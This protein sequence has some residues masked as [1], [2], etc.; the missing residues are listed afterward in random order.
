MSK[1]STAT[2][3]FHEVASGE[4][5]AWPNDRWHGAIDNCDVC[6]RPMHGERFMVDGPA[7]AGADPMWGNLCVVCAYKY[8]Q[9][10]GWGKAQLYERSDGRDWM[11][12]SGGPPGDKLY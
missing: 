12:I 3:H 7:S 11:L 4:E 5:H 2:V 9:T 8:A 10:I 6:A 1:H